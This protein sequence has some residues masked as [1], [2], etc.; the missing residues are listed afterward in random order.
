MLRASRLRRGYKLAAGRRAVRGSVDVSLSIS[1]Q[2]SLAAECSSPLETQTVNVHEAA[3][4]A[5]GSASIAV[6]S[7]C[8][9]PRIR[10]A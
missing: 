10:G 1:T 2:T 4:E 5:S 8:P 7:V 9:P 6:G 3:G